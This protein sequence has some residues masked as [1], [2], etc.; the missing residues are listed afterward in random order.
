[1]NWYAS[2]KTSSG[3]V[4]ALLLPVLVSVACEP[5]PSGVNVDVP[6]CAAE[7]TA[8]T[9]EESRYQKEKSP[10][11]PID[12]CEADMRSA[13]ES[14]ASMY[15]TSG[16]PRF[17][18]VVN[19]LA[20]EV[21]ATPTRAKDTP[22][23]SSTEDSLIGSEA[24]PVDRAVVENQFIDLFQRL[25]SEVQII[26][27]GVVRGQFDRAKD[28]KASIDVLRNNNLA[29]LAVLLEVRVNRDTYAVSVNA[30]ANYP[31]Q[32]IAIVCTGRVVRVSDGVVLGTASPARVVVHDEESLD[33]NLRRMCLCGAAELAK[34]L[35]FVPMGESKG[36]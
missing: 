22:R 15:K 12:P 14:F 28:E 9:P 36:N 4:V 8:A 21:A 17:T 2:Q 25:T 24:V 5:K 19:V 18:F 30:Q 27:L 23:L 26:D 29:D 16:R 7:G 3:T 11:Q 10:P 20:G 31:A 35:A 32:S 13:Q 1:M 33:E 6:S 34:K